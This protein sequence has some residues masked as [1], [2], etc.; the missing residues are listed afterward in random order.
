MGSRPA[1][2]ALGSGN[3]SRMYFVRFGDYLVES[4]MTW[5]PRRNVWGMSAGF[6]K[7]PLH[8]GFTRE[9]G[10]GCLSCHAGRVETIGKSD[11]HMNVK[12]LAI[13]CERCH[14]PGALHVAERK[15]N[16]PIQGGLDDSIVNLRHLS[17]ERQE[18][19][20]SQCHLTS[21]A[22]VNVHGR[23][24][25][26]FRPGQRMSDFRVSYRIDRPESAR[27][28]SG[29]IEQMR[30]SRCYIESESMTCFTCHDPHRSS[31]DAERI[32]HHRNACLRCH[33]TES[34]GE[35]AEMRAATQPSDNCIYCHM[36]KGPTDIPHFS[37]THHRVGIHDDPSGKITYTE[38]DRLVPVVDISYFPELERQRLL[39]LANDQ[40]AGKL[41][42]GL[43]DESRNDESYRELSK[44]FENRAR[45]I[46][47][48]V[49]AEGVRDP[50][51]DAYFSRSYWRTDPERCMA[52]AKSA[53][54]AATISP[55][56]RNESLFRLASSNF[57]QGRYDQALPYLQ[58]LVQNDRDEI[59]LMLLAICHQ[60]KGN[61]PEAVR[62]VHEA[63]AANPCRA[64]LH[65][66]LASVYHQ[67]GIDTREH[68]QRADLLNRR[69]PQPK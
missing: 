54:Q 43:D 11:L 55:T 3:Y 33:Q 52:Y 45:Q 40:F 15:A 65:M 18:D 61:L 68:L 20:C 1:E 13:S 51:V 39:G 6:E 5:Y 22:D 37:F 53:L 69:I 9:V 63:I 62:L 8:P 64:D 47:T 28:V 7:D 2:Y 34:C 14:G 26:G 4:P 59:N 17:R 60:K 35:S 30:Q 67:M 36:P 66:F 12:E 42:G 27:T 46:L 23:S 38:A 41:V 29:Q 32:E 56:I 49:R 57:D 16:L 58:E 21:S 19:I 48:K 24:G 10:A 44:V 25:A 31:S 50:E